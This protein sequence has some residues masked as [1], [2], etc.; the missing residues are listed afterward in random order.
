MQVAGIRRVSEQPSTFVPANA[1]QQGSWFWVD[2]PALAA[3]CRLPPDTPLVEVSLHRELPAWH[4]DWTLPAGVLPCCHLTIIWAALGL[5]AP[6][7]V[8]VG[9]H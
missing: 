1:P 7:T 3:A 9:G 4:V 6:Q 8:A 5:T 2:A